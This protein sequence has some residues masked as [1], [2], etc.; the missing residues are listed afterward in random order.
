LPKWKDEMI[1]LLSNRH[2]ALENYESALIRG[3]AKARTPGLLGAVLHDTAADTRYPAWSERYVRDVVSKEAYDAGAATDRTIVEALPARY[4]TEP[5]FDF[6][7]HSA[8]IDLA[9]ELAASDA[10]QR[11]RLDTTI[12][13]LL[14]HFGTHS[15]ALVQNML[16]GG[17]RK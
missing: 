8:Q 5:G 15:R 2:L 7:V 11:A 13:T 1:V 10:D 12:A 4:V 14:G 9:A 16:T 6:G 17:V 3:A